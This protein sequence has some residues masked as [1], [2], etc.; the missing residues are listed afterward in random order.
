MGRELPHDYVPNGGD[1]VVATHLRFG[2][3]RWL[4]G[5]FICMGGRWKFIKLFGPTKG[6]ATTTAAR[7]YAI[8]RGVWP[9][10]HEPLRDG[11][12]QK[13]KEMLVMEALRGE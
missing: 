5:L 2:G 13:T 3:N 9:V 12:E 7:K 4:L 10:M 11:K 8:R 6:L 1:I